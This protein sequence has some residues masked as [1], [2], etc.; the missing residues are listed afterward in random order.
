MS[1]ETMTVAQEVAHTIRQQ[2]TPG[3]LM[4]LGAHEQQSGTV[5]TVEG[6]DPLPSYIFKARILPFNKNGERAEA[7]RAMTVIVSLNSSDLYDIYVAYNQR[8]D[9]FGLKPR[10]V[11]FEADDVDAESLANTMLAL[12]YDGETVLNPRLA[13]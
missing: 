4:S 9:R 3:V 11:H 2:I 7:P 12:D 1:T 5:A 8:G 6:A 13:G 10:V